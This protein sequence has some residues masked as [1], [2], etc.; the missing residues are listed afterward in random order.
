M[1]DQSLLDLMHVSAR[2]TIA[3][4]PQQLYDLVADVTRTGE[5]SPI[6]ARCEWDENAGPWV[7]AWFTGYNEAPQGSMARALGGSR[8]PHAWDRRCEV[9]VADPGREF[10]FVTGG[11]ADGHARWGYV[12]RVV[13]RATEVE[14]SWRVL[15]VTAHMRAVTDAD[16]RQAVDLT[17]ANIVVTLSR[18]KA[19][20]EGR[21]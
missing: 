8:T 20:A 1:E 9:V 17:R 6:C 5:W 4:A 12:F 19:V 14:E 10:A 7:G 18:L 16:L 2:V 21:A 3:A 13:E 11:A 15:R